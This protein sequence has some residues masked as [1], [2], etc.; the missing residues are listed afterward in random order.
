MGFRKY[1]IGVLSLTVLAA[2][3]GWAAAALP[4]E[5]TPPAAPAQVSLDPRALEMLKVMSDKLSRA[6]SFSFEARSM[7]PVKSP[8]GMWIS[9][10]GTSRVVKE[11]ADKLFTETR[12]DFFPY[13]FYFDGKMITAYA[14]S[15][16]F[17]AEKK[18]PGTVDSL[19]KEIQR[20]EGRSFPYADILVARPYDVLTRGLVKAVYVG[21]ST[22]L[23]LS[24]AERV[25]TDHLAFLNKGVEWQIWLDVE[26][27]LPQRVCATYLDHP[28]EPSYTV[29]FGDWKLNEL[30][31]PETFTFRN[32]SKAAKVEFRN[33]MQQAR[34][35]FSGAADQQ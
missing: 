6:D 2:G 8:N 34:E 28:G 12:G 1:L 32:T 7:R 17:Y 23:S 22:F 24:G 35:V 20:E 19:I 15:K 9:L 5:K 10:Y 25:K 11:G 30:V 26:D 14:P 27:R 4:A 33:P 13:D 29:E 3:A 31:P 16:N 21:Q 18:A